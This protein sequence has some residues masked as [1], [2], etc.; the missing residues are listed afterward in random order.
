MR[1]RP[2]GPAALL[3]DALLSLLVYPGALGHTGTQEAV[4]RAGR[5]SWVAI[6]RDEKSK[7]L[8]T[9]VDGRKCIEMVLEP[10]GT[11]K[12]DKGPSSKKAKTTAG[13]DGDLDKDKALKE[14]RPTAPPP[15]FLL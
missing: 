7:M 5:W 13:Q 11:G 6:T 2:T 3:A 8:T 12:E 9:Y 14:V 15:R 1:A 4:L 10:E